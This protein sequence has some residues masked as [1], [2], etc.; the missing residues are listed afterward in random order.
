MILL[1]RRQIQE[2]IDSARGSV[3]RFHI[4]VWLFEVSVKYR[5][6]FLQP[7]SAL[8]SGGGA[9]AVPEAGTEVS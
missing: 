6:D 4:V 3:F 9:V 1:R 2:Q 7:G 5:V 8:G